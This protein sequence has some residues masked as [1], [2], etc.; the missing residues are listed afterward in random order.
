M[1]R[2]L[3]L[4][5]HEVSWICDVHILPLTRFEELTNYL[6]LV[7][8]VWSEIA[9][10]DLPMMRLI[11]EVT[12]KLLE[13]RAPRN[14]DE[15]ARLVKEQMHEK[16][17]FS[18]VSDVPLRRRLLT[19]LLALDRLIPS[20]HTFCK[21]TKYLEPWANAMKRLLEPGLK[22]TV[23][24]TMRAIFNQPLQQDEEGLFEQNYQHLTLRIS[25]L[26]RGSKS[27][28]ATSR[29]CILGTRQ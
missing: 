19:N 12:V 16:S 5:C 20:L 17:I 24:G 13:L 9:G 18:A 2:Y 22:S 11:D 10:D 27:R 6:H 15:D 1:R 28:S 26:S 7:Q 4:R 14:S 23:Q 8:K 21:D 3:L 29:A 25:R